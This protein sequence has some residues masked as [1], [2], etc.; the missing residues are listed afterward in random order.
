[1][2]SNNIKID[3]HIHSAAS[4]YKEDNEIVKNS[5]KENIHIL[6]NQ[7]LQRGINLFSFTDHNRF[8]SELFEFTK[9]Y[10]KDN[11]TSDGVRIS[12]IMN[13]LPG[14]EFDVL[15]E[16]GMVPCHV[17]TIFN[18]KT[19]EE[20]VR[21]KNS[22]NAD[23]LND[24]NDYYTLDRFE[25]I[26]K[27]IGLSV[28]LIVCQRKSLDNHNGKHT[29]LSDSTKQ[30]LEI[31]KYGYINAL[32]YK[33]VVNEGII[34][35]SLIENKLGQALV[36]GS[37]CHEWNAY[38]YHDSKVLKK[39]EEDHKTEDELQ[40]YSVIKALPTFKGL[41]MA[42]TSPSTRFNRIIKDKNEYVKTLK[43][44]YGEFQFSP[45]I[46]AIIGENGSGKS[47][48]LKILTKSSRERHVL[49]LQK[50]NNIIFDKYLF[51]MNYKY[52]SQSSLIEK[53]KG[54]GQLFD[55]VDEFYKEVDNSEFESKYN[56]YT[57]NLIEKIKHNISLVKYYN[58]IK[59]HEGFK[60]DVSLENLALHFIHISY[61]DDY[62]T[63]PNV[64]DSHLNNLY[65]ILDAIKNEY[66]SDYYD[67]LEKEDLK[68]SFNQIV[69]ITSNVYNKF[70]SVEYEKKIKNYIK[71]SIDEYD[72]DLSSRRTSKESEKTNY[73]NN[74]DN[75]V[76]TIMNY[77]TELNSKLD[78]VIFPNNINGISVNS[79]KGFIFQ[80]IANYHNRCLLDEF[81]QKIFVKE[82]DSEEK[83]LKIKSNEELLTALSG[84]TSGDP[85]AHYKLKVEDFLNSAIS[86][87]KNIMDEKDNDKVGAT[88]GELSLMYYKYITYND[89][90][91]DIFVIDQ[92]EDNISNLR[93]EKHLIKYFNTLRD[94]KQILIVTH[95]PLLVVNL[96]ADNV[97]CLENNSGKIK[98]KSGCL[99]DEQNKI[100]GFVEEN[101]D[102][103]KQAI[104][105]RLKFYA[106][107]N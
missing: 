81:I 48:L 19:S 85:F 35:K 1:M 37:D 82:Y 18:G 76:S 105:R 28:L 63:V 27:Q 78:D 102:G 93:I 70:I 22:I 86:T 59:N 46:N 24:K 95:N 5:T 89:N 11:K 66:I 32:E 8:D 14:V 60:F 45:G 31:L 51:G 69:N 71:T 61:N 72:T 57:K 84:I 100:I 92:P 87:Q 40:Y 103:G 62:T 41:L 65:G 99:E 13:I 55:N 3:L 12:D 56:L 104:E 2:I 21:I 101:M 15:F 54:N 42:L 97:L 26:L 39:A 43:C 96:D 58:E 36:C 30:P 34:K 73:I 80:Q 94:K 98:I 10:L 107:N 44:D 47:T 50:D 16:D 23:L 20:L 67:T 74:K 9:N 77:I 83:I 7:L 75:V 38:P 64:H 17:I 29:S 4:S 106:E 33:S 79:Q 88:L 25:T 49:K 52:I 6:I 90:E 91:I 68:K 53:Y